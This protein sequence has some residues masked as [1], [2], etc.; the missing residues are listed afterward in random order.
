MKRKGLK[1]SEL[2]V[3]EEKNKIHQFVIGKE[4]GF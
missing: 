1:K 2:K 3:D 4:E